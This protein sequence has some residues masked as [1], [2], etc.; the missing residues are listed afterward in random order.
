MKDGNIYERQP[1][2]TYELH[3][4][5]YDADKDRGVGYDDQKPIEKKLEGKGLIMSK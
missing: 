4:V 2:N 5:K 1:D 3:K